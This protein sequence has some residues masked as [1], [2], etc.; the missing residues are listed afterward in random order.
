MFQK[1]EE[2]NDILFEELKKCGDANNS[3]LMVLKSMKE[4]LDKEREMFA[5]GLYICMYR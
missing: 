2:D 5:K 4:Y 3:M 1:S